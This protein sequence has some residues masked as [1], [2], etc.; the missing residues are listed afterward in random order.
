MVF[1]RERSE[2]GAPCLARTRAIEEHLIDE[3][4]P[5]FSECLAQTVPPQASA[6]VRFPVMA[7][8]A[9]PAIATPDQMAAR[10]VA[11]LTMRQPDGEI[12]RR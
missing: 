8:I 11:R 6:S 7:D 4:E 2:H 3:C 9:E 10:R 5:G 1:A 12:D